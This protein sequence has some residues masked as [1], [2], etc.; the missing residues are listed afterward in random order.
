VEASELE[1]TFSP[2]MLETAH[3]YY[4]AAKIL[5]PHGNLG[6]V[7]VINAALAL[8]IEIVF[9]SFNSSVSANEGKLNKKYDFQR[10]K[11]SNRR[12]AHNLIELYELLP[13]EIKCK[14]HDKFTLDMLEK[15]KNVFTADR[16]FYEKTARSSYSGTLIEIA[17]KLIHISALIYKEKGCTDIWVQNYP[18]VSS[19]RT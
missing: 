5:Y 2:H 9:K 7:A 4:E 6:Q 19:I 13:K 18:N 15:Y 8:A 14:F 10:N 3:H 17:G 16:Y 1:W 12:D 11:L